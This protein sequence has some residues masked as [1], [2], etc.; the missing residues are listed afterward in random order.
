M[1]IIYCPV[2]RFCHRNGQTLGD[3]KTAQSPSIGVYGVLTYR[4][5]GLHQLFFFV[6]GQEELAPS[7]SPYLLLYDFASQIPVKLKQ[8]KLSSTFS[9][10]P[11][12][13]N[14]TFLIS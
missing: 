14:K 1:E 12:S 9:L 7:M 11:G 3:E 8:M 13:R 2:T 10:H 4:L 5:C 6:I